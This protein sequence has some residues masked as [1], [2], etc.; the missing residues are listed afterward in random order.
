[1][2]HPTS[3]LTAPQRE[4]LERLAQGKPLRGHAHGV[5]INHLKMK[6]LIL[7]SDTITDAGRAAL[8]VPDLAQQTKRPSVSDG[9]ST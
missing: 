5:T 6:R 9:K 8:G 2:K 7:D 4:A 1:M 3:G